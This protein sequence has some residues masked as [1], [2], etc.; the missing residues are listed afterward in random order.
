[1]PPLVRRHSC[2]ELSTA[3]QTRQLELHSVSVKP[4][5]AGTAEA[6]HVLPEV[7]AAGWHLARAVDDRDATLAD[8][9]GAVAPQWLVN[10]VALQSDIRVPDAEHLVMAAGDLLSVAGALPP[11]IIAFHPG[12]LPDPMV[13]VSRPRPAAGSPVS[14]SK[15][16]ASAENTDDQFLPSALQLLARYLLDTDVGVIR[17]TQSTIRHACSGRAASQNCKHG[18]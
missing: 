2:A 12:S 3:L 13:A 1:M 7:A 17:I 4:A 8:F 14:P 6:A 5:D 10:R 18:L 15:T 16:P 9:A 11:Q